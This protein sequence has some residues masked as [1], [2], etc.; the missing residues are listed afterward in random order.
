MYNSGRALITGVLRYSGN[1]T[2]VREYNIVPFDQD[3]RSN[4]TATSSNAQVKINKI[5][6][7]K[8]IQN[9][10]IFFVTTNVTENSTV[11]KVNDTITID[12]NQF[13]GNNKVNLSGKLVFTYTNGKNNF[14]PNQWIS[15]I[16]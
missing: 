9:N 14:Y 16:R 12:L 5:E 6:V 10:T 11:A 8:D 1:A 4:I 7:F 3:I 2:G 15:S 13:Q